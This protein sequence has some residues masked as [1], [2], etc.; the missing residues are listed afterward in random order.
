MYKLKKLHNGLFQIH[1]AKHP[2]AYE[3][4][5]KSIFQ[6]AITMGVEEK[7]LFVALGEMDRNYHDWAHFGVLGR[8]I[9]SGR[10]GNEGG[11]THH[12]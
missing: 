10:N 2:K 1:S 8:F 3:G 6:M 5:P 12:C 7:E 11:N 9:S 4:T